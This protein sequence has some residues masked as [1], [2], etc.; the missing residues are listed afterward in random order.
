MSKKYLACLALCLLICSITTVTFGAKHKKEA[1]RVILGIERI[2]EYA[3]IFAGK[4]VGLITNQTGVDASLKSSVDLLR[5][6]T[7][8]AGIFVPEHGLFGAVAAGEDIVDDNYEGIKVFS[9]YG[10]TKRPTE[11]MLADIDV[12]AFDIQDVGAR[13]YTYASTMAY[14]MEACSKYGKTFVVFDRPNPLGGRLGGP[15]LK[16]G[17]ESFIGLYHIP[18]RHGFT[19]GEYARFINEEYKIGADLVVI[20]MRNWTRDMYF[21]DTGLPW[22]STSPNIPTDVSAL[23]YAAT[24]IVGDLTV[25]VGVG[26][27]KP[28]EYIGAPWINKLDFAEKLNALQLPGVTFR[29]MAFVPRSNIF[30]EELCQGVQMH[31]TDKEAFLPVKTGAHIVKLLLKDYPDGAFLQGRSGDGYKIDIALGESSLRRDWPLENI[32]ARWDRE[33]D[34]FEEKAQPYLLYPQGKK[35]GYNGFK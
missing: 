22:I 3:Q 16:I 5:A 27:T 20:P 21:S 30:A 32:F 15:T 31:I 8:L 33:N 18:L 10:D 7:N 25:S 23:C 24:G 12:L 28:F 14:A 17:Q 34:I 13:H 2:D 4:R 29:P 26:T 9:L 11:A 6:K 35:G 1:E 19:M